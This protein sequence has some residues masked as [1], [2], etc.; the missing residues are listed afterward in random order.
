MQPITNL[1][2]GTGYAGAYQHIYLIFRAVVRL[3]RKQNRTEISWTT[4]WKSTNLRLLPVTAHQ[5]WTEPRTILHWRQ[6]SK[7]FFPFRNEELF[8]VPTG[9]IEIALCILGS[10]RIRSKNIRFT[11]LSPLTVI[12]GSKRPFMSGSTVCMQYTFFLNFTIVTKI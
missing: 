12:E 6:I 3:I 1:S 2:E 10:L 9:W 11:H 8:L 5:R 7:R 4:I